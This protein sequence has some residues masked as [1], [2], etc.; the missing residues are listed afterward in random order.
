MSS[1]ELM[2]SS[3]LDLA[4]QVERIRSTVD[5][6]PQGND[7]SLIEALMSG[8]VQEVL[9]AAVRLY[10]ACL[11]RDSA[12]P[13]FPHRADAPSATEALMAVTAV[14]AAVQ[15]EPFELGL[16]A[17]WGLRAPGQEEVS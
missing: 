14:L 2:M 9:A 8:G 6:L 5:V 3:G 16:W 11:E 4:A 12:V 7:E 10:A 17:T 13:A 15:I 1:S